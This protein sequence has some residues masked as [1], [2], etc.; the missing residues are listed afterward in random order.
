MLNE[1]SHAPSGSATCRCCGGHRPYATRRL[2]RPAGPGTADVR[3]GSLQR[4]GAVHGQ[5]GRCRGH[6]ASVAGVAVT[7]TG[8]SLSNETSSATAS[9]GQRLLDRNH[10]PARI[11]VIWPS[12]LRRLSCAGPVAVR[13]VSGRCRLQH[14]GDYLSAS[15]IW[16][17][18]RS[19]GRAFAY[20][21]EVVPG[22][23]K[24]G[25]GP[26]RLSNET[27]RSLGLASS[28]RLH[29]CRVCR[30]LFI[31]HY[32]AR[33]C[34][35]VCAETNYRRWVE[36]GGW[37]P[38]ILE[39]EQRLAVRCQACDR[40]FPAQRLSARFCSNRCRQKHYRDV[41]NASHMTR[42]T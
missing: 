29:H 21:A 39:T 12:P 10:S 37:P 40:A 26:W 2:R 19:T 7:V 34:S 16:V 42:Q 41:R 9:A 36:G 20:G 5:I 25:R 18:L 4:P 31:G 14:R 11:V 3:R 28:A 8:H 22:S 35:D 17:T 27:A 32:S 23:G 6:D 15:R 30:G 38:K 13:V 1:K 24:T 33:L